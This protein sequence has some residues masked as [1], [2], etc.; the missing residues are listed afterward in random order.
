MPEIKPSLL[1][2]GQV[3]HSLYYFSGPEVILNQ[4]VQE[5]QM[6]HSKVGE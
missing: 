6:T 1:H 3:S 5:V 4:E 2:I